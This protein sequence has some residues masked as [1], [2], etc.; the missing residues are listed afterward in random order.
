MSSSIAEAIQVPALASPFDPASSCTLDIYYVVDQEITCYNISNSSPTACRHW[1]LGPTTSTSACFPTSWSSSSGAYMSPGGCPIGYTVACANTDEPERTATCCPSN[2]SCE[3][4]IQGYPWFTTELCVQSMPNTI[5]YK[6]TTSTPGGT[7]ETSATTG[8]GILNAYGFAIRWHL[9]DLS[10]MT[11]TSYATPSMASS[12]STTS[13]IAT[14]IP[15][16]TTLSPSPNDISSGA[17]AGIGIGAAIAGILM[18]TGA[19]LLWRR[20]RKR[21][22]NVSTIIYDPQLIEQHQPTKGPSELAGTREQAELSGRPLPAEL[23]PGSE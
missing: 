22:Q 21:R 19:P 5:T 15:T 11:A 16:S 7:L 3:T 12:T 20:L 13:N 9:S 18:L 6:Y 8:D 2:F 14:S 10:T 23:G 1:H 17:K 4:Q